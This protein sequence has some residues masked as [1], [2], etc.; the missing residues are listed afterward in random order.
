VIG[1]LKDKLT[2]L[3]FALG[4]TASGLAMGQPVQ[5][6]LSLSQKE[7]PALLE[8]LRE[9]VAFESG[10]RELEELDRIA[11][12]IAQ[13]LRA[14]GGTVE[15]IEP[16]EADMHRLS[17]T[18]EKVGKMVRA[19]FTGSGTKKIL[20]MAHMDTVYP[21]GMLA[22]QPYRIDGDRAYGLGIAD[23]RQGIAVILHSIAM[24]RAMNY[25]DYGTLTVF[26]NADEEIGSPGSRNHHTRLGTEHDAVMSFEGGGNPQDDRLRLATSGHA[27]AQ[28][29]VRGRASHAGS[30]PERGVNALDEL[31]FQ[32]LQM[33]DLSDPATGV[34][35]NWTLARAGIVYNMIPPGAQ[36]SAD[37]RVARISDYDGIEQKL[38]ERIKK[39]LLP[40]ASV[41]LMFERRF[42]P[43]EPKPSSRAF[44]AHAQAVYRELGLTLNVLDDSAGGFTDAAN[45]SLK[46]NAPVVEGF[47]LRGFGSHTVSA[48]YVL[49]NSIQPRLYLATRMIMDAAE[50]KVPGVVPARGAEIKVLS[51]NGAK[52]AVSELAGRFEKATGHKATI[53]F[54]VNSALERKIAAGEA[55]D[56]AVLNPPVLDALVRQGKVVAATRAV[57]GRIGI[58]VGIRSGA[59][60]PDIS[61]VDAFKRALLGANAVA[62]PAEGASGKYFVAL[63]ERLGIAAQMKPKLRPM[64]A[65]YN[66]EVV[67]KGEADLV[68]V[69][70]SRMF[71]VPGVELVGLIPPELQS[72]IGFAA[73]VS[74][75]AREPEAA[76]ALVKFF[77]APAS[78]PL[79]RTMGIEPFVE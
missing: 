48:E 71:G 45:A 52:A 35:V 16:A 42:P 75:A 78:A 10:S 40:E 55:F 74:S 69:V 4:L 29:T 56:V 19:T 77:T 14:L 65:E 1:A 5:Q 32:I 63:L 23:D 44:S 37:V 46:T 25:R 64:P 79:L 49:I 3:L 17:D 57:I 27:I 72:M 15:L 41:E 24:L 11:N 18:P 31:A 58:G 59:Q 61:T 13:K 53:H 73:G 60:W 28:V 54:E 8:T 2:C 50:G 51:G 34:K 47:G 22:Q 9:L 26:I 43:L 7:A 21:R 62:F 6:V 38:R 39:K 33:R 30:A 67:A 12:L 70:A 66:V 36:A 20:L 68:V 76:R